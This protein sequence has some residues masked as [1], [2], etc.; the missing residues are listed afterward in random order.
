[1]LFHHIKHPAA[2]RARVH[3]QRPAD[4][5]WYAF[6]KFRPVNCARFAS[7]A[8]AFNFAPAPQCKRTPIS[9][10]RLK[11]GCAR[12]ITMARIP[13]SLIN[14]ST[15]RPRMKNGTAPPQIWQNPR[16]LRLRRW[17]RNTHPRPPTRNVVRFAS[18]SSGRK[19]VAA[20]SEAFNSAMTSL[21]TQA[22]F[23]FSTGFEKNPLPHRSGSRNRGLMGSLNSAHPQPR[24]TQITMSAAHSKKT[25]ARHVD[26]SA[27]P[28]ASLPKSRRARAPENAPGARPWD[29]PK[30][31]HRA[32]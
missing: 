13:P 24:D 3:P 17:A 29:K 19:T 7:I 30:P 25:R 12:Q 27:R 31:R 20:D 10:T 22:H 23:P 5:S 15:P 2:H 28:T 4:R 8:T 26:L 6:E 32:S 1:M 18:I 11:F 16:Q 21:W 14:N 9:S